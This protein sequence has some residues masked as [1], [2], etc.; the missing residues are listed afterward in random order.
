MKNAIK[1]CLSLSVIFAVTAPTV[2]SQT[3]A[4]ANSLLTVNTLKTADAAVNANWAWARGYT[5]TGSTILFM[6]SGI[7]VKNVDFAGRIRYTIDYTNTGIQD[8]V[9]HGTNVAGIA[10]AANNNIGTT[11][12]A[13]G[14]SI[15]VA[16]ITNNDSASFVAARQA[17]AW[18]SQ[19]SDI[20][21]A[22]LS[23][24]TNYSTAYMAA[25]KQ[26]APGM[27]INTDKNYGGLAYYNL[28]KPTDW[29][30]P[31][32]T[33]LV[34]SAGNQGTP[35]VQNPATFA[36]ATDAAGKLI[37]GGQ[38]I[39]VGNWNTSLNIQQGDQSGTMCKNYQNNAC[40]DKYRMS[41]FYIMAPGTG[42]LSTG[43]KGDGSTSTMSGT[44]Q[45]APAVSGAV[46]IVH[47]M[48]PYMTGANIVQLLLKTANKNLPG[49]NV[50][51]M[52]QGLLDLNRATQ[53]IGNLGISTTGRTGTVT[54]I[55]GGLSIAGG[56]SSGSLSSIMSRVSVVD[57][58]QRDYTVNMS[59]MVSKNSFASDPMTMDNEPGYSWSSRWTGVSN[60]YL[61]G[62]MG[63]QAGKNAT[64]TFDSAY[65]DPTSAVRHQV[66]MTQSE[67]NPYVNFSGA[68][69]QTKISNTYEYST[70]YRPN[71]QGAWAQAGVMQ[72]VTQFTPGM[73]QS[74]TPIYSAY[75]T[76]GYQLGNWNT[77]TGVKPTIVSGNITVNVPTG[78]DADG[79]M[80]YNS[81][82]ASLAGDR[83]IPYAGT[84]YQYTTRDGQTYGARLMAA[85][86]SS[87][88]AKLYYRYRF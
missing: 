21:A 6:D 5:G 2:H 25:S 31:G 39:V 53:P 20:V 54:P 78:V 44:S 34:V 14:A 29:K 86:D 18:S 36:T 70:M 73:V 57:G 50:N 68:W 45:A 37:L 65:F 62:F 24:N 10:T 82:K 35:Y 84:Q 67:M 60:T 77:F 30:I 88:A 71:P 55:V 11:G 42:I 38:M 75:A 28:E 23:A 69:G 61:P 72:T 59:P 7:D 26:V 49:Y 81:V 40:L 43:I 46:A 27:Y 22:N 56:G 1:F 33:V 15:A 64:V 16:K 32:Q 41:D 13:Y 52:G 8:K 83:A 12:I 80:Q 63:G 51:T 85:Q 19:Y 17:L 4:Q 66:T 58:L 87:Y 74:V 79:N 3:A 48:W 76:A 9:G 47:Q